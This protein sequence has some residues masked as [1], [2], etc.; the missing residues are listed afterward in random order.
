MS[1]LIQKIPYLTWLKIHAHGTKS[2]VITMLNE[3]GRVNG[4]SQLLGAVVDQ[5]VKS[6]GTRREV[7][8]ENHQI[9]HDLGTDIQTRR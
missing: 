5:F 8:Y 3:L 6:G 7:L 1:K 2:Y 4:V 9:L